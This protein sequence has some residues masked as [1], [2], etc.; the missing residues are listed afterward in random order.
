MRTV[1]AHIL[2]MTITVHLFYSS[3]FLLD[4]YVNSDTYKANCENI[5]RPELNCD[6][7]CILALKMKSSDQSEQ[8]KLAPIPSNF[9]F[10]KSELPT[11]LGSTLLAESDNTFV[12]QNYNYMVLLD[13]F[14]PPQ[15][16]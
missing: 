16:G 8:R 7:K 4:Y 14:R 5:D 11:L 3:G 9:E 13:C 2:L 6:G 1:I 12:T 15:K 10:F